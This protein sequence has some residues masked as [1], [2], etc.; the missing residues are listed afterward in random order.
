MRSR[1]YSS[2]R[3]D[4]NDLEE[5]KYPMA[6]SKSGRIQ[7]LTRMLPEEQ[8]EEEKEFE[9]QV[10]QIQDGS[11]ENRNRFRQNSIVDS[12]ASSFIT[13][14]QSAIP[15]MTEIEFSNPIMDSLGASAVSN[16][17]GGNLSSGQ[18]PFGATPTPG[19]APPANNP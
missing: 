9:C 11:A 5:H 19:D 17:L 2:D 13:M 3:E 12:E 15:S 4:L 10:S 8:K 14:Q 7:Q 6:R 18:S 16:M 1:K